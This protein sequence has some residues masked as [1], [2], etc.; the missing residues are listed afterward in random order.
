[1]ARGTDERVTDRVPVL[2][3]CSSR[4]RS[5]I[6]RAMAYPDRAVRSLVAA[7]GALPGVLRCSGGAR[8]RV[9]A[10]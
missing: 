4:E 9:G 8:Y 3:S 2:S 10:P 7:L 1:M 6:Q 5:Y